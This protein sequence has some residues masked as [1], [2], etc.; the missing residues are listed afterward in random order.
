MR[1]ELN[2]RRR[3]PQ[4]LA[5]TLWACAA[6]C[7]H[8]QE[9]VPA[10]ARP[11]A[12]LGG[13]L[14]LGNGEVIANGS[15]LFD[16]G[17]IVALGARI[18]L[19]ANAEQIDLAGAHVYPG[20]ILLDS[21]L[22]L[23]EVEAVRAT[24]DNT[25]FGEL[26]PNVRSADAYN[27]DSELLPVTR[28][29]GVLSAQIAPTGGLISGRSSVMKLDAWT[30]EEALLRADDGVWLNWPQR[31][32]TQIDENTLE[33]ALTEN[34][35]YARQMGELEDL[36][37]QASTYRRAAPSP[38]N[39]KL[40]ALGPLFEGTARLYVRTDYAADFDAAMAFAER[41][42]ISAMAWVGAAEAEQL[43]ARLVESNIP[44]VISAVHRLPI[45]PDSPFDQAYQLAAHLHQA[46]VTVALTHSY[47]MNARNLAFQAGSARTYGVPAE[48]ALAM[49][50]SVPAQL[51]GLADELGTLKVG[52]R[53]TLFVSEGDVLEM[54]GNRLTRAYIDGMAVNL[55]GRQQRLYQRYRERYQRGD[56]VPATD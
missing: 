39:L 28:F 8:A 10:A 21:T 5:L 31:L 37:A 30:A 6:V 55:Q 53:A 48:Q 34:P 29:N 32:V 51:L 13:T 49:I 16:Q 3:W 41:H 22:G 54:R 2:Q 42:Q 23:I 43:A 9:P 15:L 46:G 36:F 35:E 52:A 7:T 27:V 24:L 17:R 20:L 45:Y 47:Y 18:Q 1:S 4:L 33:A 11:T 25:E 44:V 56:Q 14:H 40:E 19:P 12:L 26:N 50:T 38:R